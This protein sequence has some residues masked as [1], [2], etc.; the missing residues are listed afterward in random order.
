[1]THFLLGWDRNIY[2]IHVELYL[3]HEYILLFLLSH[4][5]K[6]SVDIW[7]LALQL[8]F[9]G[10]S[11]PKVLKLGFWTIY[12]C[13]HTFSFNRI[14]TRRILIF[15]RCKLDLYKWP[16]WP[17][18]LLCVWSGQGQPTHAERHSVS[19]RYCPP[20]HWSHLSSRPLLSWRHRLPH[21]L[22]SRILPR[23]DQPGRL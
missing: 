5:M 19:S 6:A 14:E 18:L 7:K 13:H 4:K 9:I 23:F 16:L 21:R 10:L 22:S 1:M 12:I 20:Y 8:K 15:D 2:M 17:R 3:V 11:R